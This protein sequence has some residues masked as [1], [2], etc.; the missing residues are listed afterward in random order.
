[1]P[2]SS[3]TGSVPLNPF[4]GFIPMGG[5]IVI[6]TFTDP[7]THVFLLGPGGVTDTIY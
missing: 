3:S 6:A 1:M 7:V 4:K 5:D 2:L